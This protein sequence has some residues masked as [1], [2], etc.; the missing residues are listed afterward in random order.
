M[1]KN[2]KSLYLT[3]KTDNMKTKVKFSKKR[4]F[5]SGKNSTFNED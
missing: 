4:K 2:L 1:S 3:G 5:T